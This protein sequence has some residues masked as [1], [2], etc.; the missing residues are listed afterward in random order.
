MLTVA[1]DLSRRRELTNI[2]KTETI[3]FL[4]LRPVHTVV[5]TSFIR[6]NGI[7]NSL[8]QGKFFGYRNEQRELEGVA[9]I[10]HTTLVEAQI[11]AA[12]K[13]LA[14]TV[15]SNDVFLDGERASHVEPVLE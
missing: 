6:D 2:N 9:P 10:G 15:M 11:D 3:A 4:A 7:E 14:F 5:M 8:N 13:A 1:P 12:L